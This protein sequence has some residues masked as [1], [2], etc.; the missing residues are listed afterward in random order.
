MKY[1]I[2]IFAIF[3]FSTI[4]Y[5][6]TTDHQMEELARE[7]CHST[8]AKDSPQRIRMHNALVKI[9]PGIPSG[10]TITYITINPTGKFTAW[11]RVQPDHSVTCIPTDYIDFESD[12]ELEFTLSHETGHSV[13]EF[14]YGHDRSTEQQMCEF[15]ADD[16]AFGILRKAG[17]NPD[18]AVSLFKKKHQPRRIKNFEKWKKSQRA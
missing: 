12:S 16:I 13:D 10:H 2:A 5:C 11:T 6:E 4:S 15:R 7:V 1:A 3:V 8:W 9:R 14:C 17:I 18:V